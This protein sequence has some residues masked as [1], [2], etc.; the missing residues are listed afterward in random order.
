M[1]FVARL[2]ARI[3]TFLGLVA[4]IIPG[5]ILAVRYSLLE[6]TVILECL[7]HEE[8]RARS[9]ELTSG[10]R[11]RIFAA[12]ILFVLSY[13]VLSFASYWGFNLFFTTIMPENITDFFKWGM[14]SVN[15]GMDCALDI[16]FAIIWIV[17]F[18]FY[19]EAT[20]EDSPELMVQESLP[21]GME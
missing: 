12:A 13:L 3:L 16:Y 4:L 10:R 2:C 21:V 20:H 17:L 19:W 18:L 1:L 8:A 5:I 14:M 9:V 6:Q 15:I 7:G 11:W